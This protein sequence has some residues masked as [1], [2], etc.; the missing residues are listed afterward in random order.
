MLNTGRSDRGPPRPRYS[1][2]YPTHFDAADNDNLLNWCFTTMAYN[3]GGDTG[4]PGSANESC[5]AG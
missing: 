4:S 1:R 3:A 2:L 5:P